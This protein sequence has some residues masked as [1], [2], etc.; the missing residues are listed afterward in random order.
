MQMISEAS[1]DN[2]LPAILWSCKEAMFKWWGRGGIDFSEMLRLSALE[3]SAEFFN[4]TFIKGSFKTEFPV[5]Y[6]LF[7]QLV[8]SWVITDPQQE[9]DLKS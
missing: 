5:Y 8:L 9:P 7:Q 2:L 4:G 6:K 3:K 1:R